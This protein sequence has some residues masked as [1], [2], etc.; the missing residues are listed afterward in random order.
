MSVAQYDLPLMIALVLPG[1]KKYKSP[2][3]P[4]DLTVEAI[5]SFI[6]DILEEKAIRTLKS[7][8]VPDKNDG[9][10][11]VIVGT[12]WKDIVLDGTK[13]VFVMYYAPWCGHCKALAPIWEEMGKE[14]ANN[15][16]LVFAKFDATSNEVEGLPQIPG[17]PTLVYYQ[18]HNK[19]GILYEEKDRS[20]EAIISW[21][22]M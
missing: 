16:E 14:F 18:M 8:P 10:V 13:E 22:N 15:K 19:A 20:K 4:E 7:E 21:M 6:D 17:Y 5:G 3:A 12:Q 2:I 11:K 1:D 9:P